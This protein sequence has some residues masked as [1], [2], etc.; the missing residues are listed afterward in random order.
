[1]NKFKTFCEKY[2]FVEDVDK[3]QLNHIFSKKCFKILHVDLYSDNPYMLFS[4]IIEKNVFVSLKDGRIVIKKKD[5]H[6]TS[7]I[8]I[9]LDNIEHCIIKQYNDSQYELIFTIHNLWYKLLVII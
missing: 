9:L 7:L 3:I 8:D 1:M 4:R 5:K 6:N 2:G